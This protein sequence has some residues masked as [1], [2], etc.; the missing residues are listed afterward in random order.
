MQIIPDQLLEASR[1]FNEASKD[2]QSIVNQ[3]E[4]TMGKLQESWS[5]QVNRPF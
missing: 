1:D 5:T 2:I 4:I 3:L